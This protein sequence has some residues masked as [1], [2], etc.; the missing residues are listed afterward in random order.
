M[1]IKTSKSSGHIDKRVTCEQCASRYLYRLVRSKRAISI[2]PLI[3]LFGAIAALPLLVVV[4][5]PCLF[6]PLGGGFIIIMRFRTGGPL[7]LGNLYR[8][9]GE[10]GD[11]DADISANKKLREAFLK[12]AEPV[13]CPECG[14]YQKDMV[15]EYQRRQLR[16]ILWLGLSILLASQAVAYWLMT[17]DKNRA[18]GSFQTGPDHKVQ[19]WLICVGLGGIFAL[20]AI[21]LRWLLAL[22]RNPNNGFPE[23]RAPVPGA[24]PAVREA[25]FNDD[26]VSAT[27]RITAR[28]PIQ[29]ETR[30]LPH[31]R[32]P[33]PQ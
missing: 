22:G 29:V 15:R 12:G 10:A 33:P 4:F 18:F 31:R 28:R 9:S 11:E 2:L 8:G 24:P 7:A 6:I 25:D 23:K 26:L 32:L 20:T 13:P 21:S 3:M 19:S 30:V 5:S 27:A 1:L 17:L 16:W 14:W